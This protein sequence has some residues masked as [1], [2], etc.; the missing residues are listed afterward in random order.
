MGSFSVLKSNG[1]LIVN[2]SLLGKSFLTLCSNLTIASLIFVTAVASF[3]LPVQGQSANGRQLQA[4]DYQ[5]IL[6]GSEARSG[7]KRA[8]GGLCKNRAALNSSAFGANQNSH[9]VGRVN[10]STAQQTGL[11]NPETILVDSVIVQN[12]QVDTNRLTVYLSNCSASSGVVQLRSEVLDLQQAIS[13]ESTW[14]RRRVPRYD[15][16][17]HSLTIPQ[18][19]DPSSVRIYLRADDSSSVYEL[20]VAASRIR[21]SVFPSSTGELYTD[22]RTW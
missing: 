6:K 15:Y 17:V 10:G 13:I 1:D 3:M 18:G 7:A 14:E 4:A 12:E 21:K 8:S 11:L 2:K 9:R 5:S 22:N 20:E 19:L 16:L